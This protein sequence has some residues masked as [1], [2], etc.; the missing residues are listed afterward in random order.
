M[1]CKWCGSHFPEQELL[2][3]VCLACLI[4]DCVDYFVLVRALKEDED[5]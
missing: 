2:E 3:S 5:E 1:N 4:E